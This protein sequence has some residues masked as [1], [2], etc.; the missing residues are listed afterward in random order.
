MSSV[1]HFGQ[2]CCA[3]ACRS[4]DVALARVLGLHADGGAGPDMRRWLQQEA[5]CFLGCFTSLSLPYGI[6]PI[7]RH[8]AVEIIKICLA[9]GSKAHAEQLKHLANIEPN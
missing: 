7:N 4:Q 3:Q 5:T 1:C 8:K 9:I 2:H 6:A